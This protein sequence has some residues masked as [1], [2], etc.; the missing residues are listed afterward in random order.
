MLLIGLDGS[1]KT[2]ILHTL[3]N[4]KRIDFT[5]T[6][7]CQNHN[8]NYMGTEVSLTEL[9]GS[10]SIRGIWKHYY[11]EAHGAIFVIDTTNHD[12][13]LIARSLLSSIFL[14]TK[15]AGKPI[16]VIGSK[17]DLDGAIDYLD[18]CTYLDIEHM[19]N[20]S[21]TPCFVAAIGQDETNDLHS[22][23]EWLT[24]TIIANLRRIHNQNEYFLFVDSARY[25]DQLNGRPKTSRSFKRV[26]I[27]K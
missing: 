3:W 25:T 17:Q 9:G 22:G 14:Q 4:K 2:E 24:Q 5:P 10:K 13:L 21:R 20:L 19:A 11:Q 18:F 6:V 23:M 15:L 27:V 12:R 1:G 16:L 26:C 8:F 7:G